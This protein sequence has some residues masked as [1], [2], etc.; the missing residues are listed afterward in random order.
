LANVLLSG[1]RPYREF[2]LD[3]VLRHLRT[4][5]CER[6]RFSGSRQ[7]GWLSVADVSGLMSEDRAINRQYGEIEDH[8]R[9]AAPG[10]QFP[11]VHGRNFPADRKAKACAEIAPVRAPPEARKE[12]RE[13]FG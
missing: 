1:D 2:P 9:L 8:A 4:Q 3:W 11:T 13:I 7:S 5:V 6:W 12:F 10:L